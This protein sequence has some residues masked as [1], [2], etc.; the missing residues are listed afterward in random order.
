MTNYTFVS[1]HTLVNLGDG[2][3]SLI[4]DDGGITTTANLARLVDNVMCFSYPIVTRVESQLV[5]LSTTKNKAYYKLPHWD[6]VYRVYTFKFTVCDINADALR[7]RLDNI[8]LVIPT[9]VH[10]E[11]AAVRLTRFITAGTNRNTTIICNS[12]A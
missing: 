6:G 7:K 2:H 4:N 11:S 12:F 8:P 1:I 5:D 3:T 10:Q 9:Y